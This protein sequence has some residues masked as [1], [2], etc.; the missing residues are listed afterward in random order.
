MADSANRLLAQLLPHVSPAA[1]GELVRQARFASHPAEVTL[2]HEGEKEDG[3][4]VIIEGR[5]DVFKMLEGQRLHVNQLGVGAHFGDLSLL[6][7]VPRTATIVTAEPTRVIEIDRALFGELVRTN[8]EAVVALSRLALQRLLSQTEKHLMEI[9]RLKK[10]GTPPGRVFISYAREDEAFATR[11]ANNLLKQEIDVWLD[12]YRIMPGRSWARQIGEALDACQIML[13]VLSAS[14]VASENVEDEWNY[15]LDQKKCTLCV[16]IE[17]C[18]VPYR[19][20]K[21]QYVDFHL[22]DYDQALA[23]VV[24]TLNT[25]D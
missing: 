24:A 22:A 23:R 2:C 6:L 13:V 25:L 12:T 21:L 4:Y 5:V 19:L 11:L 14:S 1:V 8:P 9:A 7:D 16:R 20:S 3:F 15:Y 10:H 17:P 18:K